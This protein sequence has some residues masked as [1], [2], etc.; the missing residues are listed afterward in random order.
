M[1]VL[2]IPDKQKQDDKD[3]KKL[4]RVREIINE[5][6]HALAGLYEAEREII[7]RLGVNKP[8]NGPEVA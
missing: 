3:R 6:H 7:N 2:N 5:Y 1:S 4:A 8:G